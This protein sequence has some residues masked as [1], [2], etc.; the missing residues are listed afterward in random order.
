MWHRSRGGGW[1]QRGCSRRHLWLGISL[2]EPRVRGSLRRR[3]RGGVLGQLFCRLR[4]FGV[5]WRWIGLRGLCSSRE[6][7]VV[8]FLS[9]RSESRRVPDITVNLCRRLDKCEDVGGEYVD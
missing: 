9:V 2:F 6:L 3:G 1:G 8:S 7:G 4:G 5:A